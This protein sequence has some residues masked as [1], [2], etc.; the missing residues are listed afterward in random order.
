MKKQKMNKGI[1]LIALIITIIVLLI[2][3]VVA[4]SAVTENGI[5]A[6]AKNARDVYSEKSEEEKDI[7]SIL[8]NNINNNIGTNGKEFTVRFLNYDE[9]VLQVVSVK[10]G[11]SAKYTQELPTK[12]ASDTEGCYKFSKWVTS[13]DGKE[14]ANLKNIDS[15]LDVYASYVRMVD[16]TTTDTINIMDVRNVKNQ[17]DIYEVLTWSEDTD[18]ALTV[19]ENLKNSN[20]TFTEIFSSKN[21]IDTLNLNEFVILK[22]NLEDEIDSDIAC[23]ISFST[24]YYQ[25]L[26]IHPFMAIVSNTDE[27]KW[28]ELECTI[29]ENSGHLVITIPSKILEKI[30]YSNENI[31][32]LAVLND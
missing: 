5:I 10:E 31:A 15:N 14:V 18:E 16:K 9:A 4:I 12:P 21:D 32:V 22:F 20:K 6:H 30:F 19:F 3:A 17:E 23:E 8:E 11:E 29:K 25:N 27:I 26:N 28:F 24:Q 7:L 13:K 2:L 1:T